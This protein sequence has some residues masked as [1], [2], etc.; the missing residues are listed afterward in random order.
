MTSKIGAYFVMTAWIF[1]LV[2]MSLPQSGSLYAQDATNSDAS[3]NS[4][5]EIPIA[6]DSSFDFSDAV[7]CSVVETLP[8]IENIVASHYGSSMGTCYGGYG[9]RLY[10]NDEYFVALPAKSDSLNCLGGMLGCRMSRCG[11]AQPELDNLL[12]NSSPESDPSF[13]EFCFWPVEQEQVI[14]GWIIEGTEGEGLFRVIEIKPA[15]QEGPIL[16]AYVGDVGPWN[17]YDP[18][19]QDYS[20]P[21]AE[22]GIDSRGRRTNLAGIDLSYALAVALGFTGMS[23]IDW[24][25]KT[26]DGKYVVRRQPTE[27]RW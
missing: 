5:P 26:V 20:R 7:Q 4:Q 11:A 19:W 9:N 17:Q 21:D 22:D 24:R 23:E 8:W 15:G 25:W 6:S 13:E 2:S 1:I 3:E 27:W 10:P 12:N 18:Y 16:E 14:D